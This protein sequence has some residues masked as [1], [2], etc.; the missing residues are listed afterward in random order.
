[1]SRA[2]RLVGLQDKRLRVKL[3][4]FPFAA[5]I[6]RYASDIWLLL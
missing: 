3:V 2:A 6:L 5:K 4:P 1:M